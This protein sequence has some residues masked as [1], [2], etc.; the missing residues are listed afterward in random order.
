[1]K[2]K[3]SNDFL[4]K[5]CERLSAKWQS[6]KFHGSILKCTF[7][8]SVCICKHILFFIS[9]CLT[10]YLFFL[11]H[12]CYICNIYY[13]FMSYVTSYFFHIHFILYVISFVPVVWSAVENDSIQNPFMMS[14][15]S[16]HMLN[17]TLH[18]YTSCAEYYTK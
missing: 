14:S 10:K 12:Y 3:Q 6:F 15:R 1:M 9:S 4:F 5:E 7:I 2:R 8:L 11:P 18:Y 17:T 16:M 13:L